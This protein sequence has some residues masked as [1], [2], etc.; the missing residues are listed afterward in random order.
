MSLQSQSGGSAAANLITSAAVSSFQD[1]SNCRFKQLMQSLVQHI[2]GFV[3]E[4]NLTE[5]E[6]LSCMKFLVD[7]GKMCS[8]TRNEFMLMSDVLGLTSL[9]NINTMASDGREDLSTPPTGC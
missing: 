9:V 7:T 2:H 3:N 4:N 8:D 6:W 1:A 5:E